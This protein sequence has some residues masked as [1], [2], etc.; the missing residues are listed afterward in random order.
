MPKIRIEG[1]A[2]TESPATS[3][4]VAAKALAPISKRQQ[5]NKRTR[6]KLELFQEH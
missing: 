2:I 6:A 1:P 3:A 4:F 5:T